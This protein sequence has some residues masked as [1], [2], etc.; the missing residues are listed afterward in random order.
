VATQRARVTRVAHG[1]DTGMAFEPL[2]AGAP[3]GD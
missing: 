3:P 1:S 2:A